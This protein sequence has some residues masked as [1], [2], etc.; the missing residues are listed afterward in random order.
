M[1]G[2]RIKLIVIGLLVLSLLAMPLFAACAKPTPAPAP[3]PSPAPAPATERTITLGFL[4]GFTGPLAVPTKLQFNMCQAYYTWASETGLIPGI[5]FNMVTEDT[6]Y[7]MA[8]IVPA[9]MRMQPKKPM[10][11]QFIYS[12]DGDTIKP[13]C[14]RDMVP[15]VGYVTSTLAID[16][17]EF[18]F[19]ASPLWDNYET[20]VLNWIQDTWDMDKMGRP[21]RYA[22]LGWD[23]T[24]GTCGV[25]AGELY[26]AKLDKVEHV[27]AE[28]SPPRTMDFSTYMVRLKKADPDYI[29]CPLVSGPFASAVKTAV[30]LG[31]KPSQ[32][33]AAGSTTGQWEAVVS[34]VGAQELNG[35]L[36]ASDQYQYSDNAKG[37]QLM[38]DL[39]KKAGYE[40]PIIASNWMWGIG[41]MFVIPEAVRIAVEDVGV[42]QLDSA[43]IYRALQKI[44]NFD[45]EAMAPI[46]FGLDR[47]DGIRSMRMYE[48]RDGKDFYLL[49]DKL[50][51]AKP[52]AAEVLKEAGK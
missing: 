32:F 31:M 11:I 28:I 51:Y 40:P 24:M 21:A 27:G 45:T 26:A 25:E 5:K 10:I 16:P 13:L 22:H 49:S 48:W 35:V 4:S 38:V 23:N 36:H 42:D 9:Y 39:W 19:S 15:A 17:P 6:R 1:K 50:Y 43:D 37:I 7:D 52:T 47:R 20:M 2:N 8:Q 12:Q 30:E 14:A 34:A 46:T 41:P 18:V 44:Q 29:W 3:A 33:I